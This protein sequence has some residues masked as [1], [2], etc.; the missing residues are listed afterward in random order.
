MV[1]PLCIS[2]N[3]LTLGALVCSC[4]ESPKF[5]LSRRAPA[6]VCLTITRHVV[7]S[8]LFPDAV[9]VGVYD[10]CKLIRLYAMIDFI[11]AV[12]VYKLSKQ[13]DVF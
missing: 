3:G 13:G 10:L 2:V 7:F 1:G 5:G 12:F 9:I 6:T 11:G 4:E 8:A